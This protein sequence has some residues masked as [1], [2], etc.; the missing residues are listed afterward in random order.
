MWELFPKINLKY[1]LRSCQ[2]VEIPKTSTRFGMKSIVFPGALAWNHLPKA[3]KDIPSL[4]DFKNVLKGT[5][6]HCHCKI[7]S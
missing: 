4:L 2:N 6:I 1:G 5:K 3:L 7:C